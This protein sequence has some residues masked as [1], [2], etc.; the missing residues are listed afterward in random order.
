M[1]RKQI[2][3]SSVQHEFAYARDK[4]ASFINNDPYWSQ[5]FYAFIFE[6]LPASRQSPSDIY[7]GEIDRC[8]VYLGIFGL[9]YGRLNEDGISATEQEFDYAIK[10]GRDPLIFVKNLTPKACRAKRMQALIRKASAYTYTTFRNT[11]HLC[12]E[13]QRSLLYWQQDQNRRTAK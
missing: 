6:N 1:K 3:I 11:D 4:L 7:L 10:I 13:V 2:F 12:S 8:A 5:F 9:H